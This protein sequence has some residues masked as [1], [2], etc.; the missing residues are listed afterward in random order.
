MK[1]KKILALLL[2]LTTTISMTS[3]TSFAA[4]RELLG[5]FSQYFLDTG[6]YIGYPLTSVDTDLI[7]KADEYSL[8]P[9][10]MDDDNRYELDVPD[11]RVV[12]VVA[13]FETGKDQCGTGF[14]ISDQVVA[15]SAHIITNDED[16]FPNKVTIYPGLDDLPLYSDNYYKGESVVV[17]TK[18]FSPND[19]AYDYALVTLSEPANVGYFGFTGEHSV[20]EKVKTIGYPQ[21][22]LYHQYGCDGEITNI[23]SNFLMAD[24]KSSHGQSGSPLFD[25][26]NLVHG[27]L[28]GSDFT[29]NEVGFVKI[30]RTIFTLF[31]AYRTDPLFAVHLFD[32]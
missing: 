19:T 13:E 22:H 31:L 2:A 30:D 6:R 16:Y 1:S 7:A 25:D 15:T 21:E 27:V 29:T 32:K 23:L 5:Y 26:N 24:L 8:M 20:G 14:F 4:E 10:S 17:S 3:I 9:S 12:Y 18:Y 11:P 28:R